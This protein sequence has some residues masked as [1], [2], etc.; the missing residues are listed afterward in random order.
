MSSLQQTHQI[1][2][3]GNRD[4]QFV[5][6]SEVPAQN[7]SEP[8]YH[9]LVH[10]CNQVDPHSHLFADVTLNTSSLE[11]VIKLVEQAVGTSWSYQQIWLPVQDWLSTGALLDS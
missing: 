5:Q 2:P 4:A 7:G 3:L 8:H 10:C 6:I 1:Q 9:F 11:A